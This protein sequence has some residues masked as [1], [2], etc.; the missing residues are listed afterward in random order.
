[1]TVSSTVI[2]ASSPLGAT[3]NLRFPI[4]SQDAPFST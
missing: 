4:S 3:V 2:V 1:L